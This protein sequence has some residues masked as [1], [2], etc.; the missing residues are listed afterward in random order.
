MPQLAMLPDDAAYDDYGVSNKF[1]S[2]ELFGKEKESD[3]ENNEVFEV[4]EDDVGCGR[5][6]AD[7]VHD[8]DIEG[9]CEKAGE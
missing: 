7:E 3:G 9:K 2:S 1:I 6:L 5:Q 4:V 8:A